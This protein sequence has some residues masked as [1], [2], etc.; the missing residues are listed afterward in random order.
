MPFPFFRHKQADD[1]ILG[2]L[3]R[4]RFSKPCVVKTPARSTHLYVVGKTGKGKS[5][6]LQSCLYQDVANGRG[7]GVIDPHSRLIEDLLGQLLA[8]GALDHPAQ[9]SRLVYVEPTRTDYVVPFNILATP[10]NP[11]E[12]AQ[13]VIEAFHRTWDLAD[14]PRFDN[15]L[16]H[17]LLLLI[18][19]HLTL[20]DLPRLLTSRDFRDDL[21]ERTQDGELRAFFHDRFDQWGRDT[22]LMIES[23]LNKATA[24]TM[25]PYLKLML[26]QPGNHLDFRALMDGGHVLMV[27]LGRCRDESQRLIGNLI[28][29]GLEQAVFSRADLPAQDIR[30]FYLYIDEFQD[31][32]ASDEKALYKILS[33]ARKFGLYLTLAHQNQSQL[34]E[35]MRGAIMG[36]V[37]LKVIFGIS[38]TD[39][40][41][42]A[43][44]VGMGNIDTEAVKHEAP[45]DSQHPVFTPLTEQFYRWAETLATQQPRQAILRDHEGNTRP[46]WVTAVPDSHAPTEALKAA[47]MAAWGIPAAQARQNLN[48]PPLKQPSPAV[49]PPAYD[50]IAL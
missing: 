7:C 30:R 18:Q 50:R 16:L 4:F 6:F 20:I 38:E 32:S 3:G 24:L 47:S 35:R 9:A 23:V 43:Q 8:S 40:L 46:L 17:A 5:K 33:G 26:G 12:V 39:A 10:G 21:L 44:L 41:H 2:R 48:R 14:A 37:G 49:R 29:T 28:T 22:P 27:D 42:L 15:V 34:S 11:Y 25:N 13:G 36:N 1:L 45:T 31:F 19:T